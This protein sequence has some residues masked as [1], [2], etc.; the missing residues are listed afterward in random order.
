MKNENLGGIP[1]GT[2]PM[3]VKV[4]HSSMLSEC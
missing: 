4:G 3:L 1:G 2:N